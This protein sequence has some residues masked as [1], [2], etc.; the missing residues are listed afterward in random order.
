MACHL[1][2]TGGVVAMVDAPD[3]HQWCLDWNIRTI[4]HGQKHKARYMEREIVGEGGRI[5]L[6]AI[7]CGS[8]LGPK[9]RQCTTCS[10]GIQAHSAGSC[11]SLKASMAVHFVRP[12]RRFLRTN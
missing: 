3:L 8:F 12:S 5:N 4:L 11:R 7:G 6:T 1:A 10:S 9:E 2:A